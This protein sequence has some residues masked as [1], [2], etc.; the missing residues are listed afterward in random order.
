[1][2][3]YVI[4][5]RTVSAANARE[6]WAAKHRRVSRERAAAVI[7][8][9]HPL[10]CVVRLVRIAGP[11]GRMLDDDN[12]VSALKPLRDGIADRLGVDDADPRV[13]WEYSQERGEAWAVRVEIAA[14]TR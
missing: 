2:T 6:H 7:V 14:V 3:T 9:P 11:R 5:L 4:P 8:R 1:M 12:A 10:P 13:R